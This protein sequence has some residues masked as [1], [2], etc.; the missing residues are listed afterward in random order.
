MLLANWEDVT[1][2]IGSVLRCPEDWQPHNEY[3]TYFYYSEDA[4]GTGRKDT[5]LKEC[6]LVAYQYVTSKTGRVSTARSH[7]TI[8]KLY[9]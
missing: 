1:T 5:G 8:S 4:C 9:R 2:I 3:V 6:V 7:V